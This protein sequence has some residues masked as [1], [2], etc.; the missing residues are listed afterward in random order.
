[1]KAMQHTQHLI[2]SIILWV[3]SLLMYFF[4]VEMLD[5]FYI[6]FFRLLSIISLFLIIGVN[7]E[8]GIEGI[9]KIFKK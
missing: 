9:K 2:L 7:F 4:S 5:S 1:M 6:W 8:K 3:N